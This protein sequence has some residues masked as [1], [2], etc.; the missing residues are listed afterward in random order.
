MKRSTQAMALAGALLLTIAPPASSQVAHPG[1]SGLISTPTPDVMQ[2][3]S[4]ALTF[5]WLDGPD[6]YL[7]T[8]LTNRVYGVTAG[9]LPNLEVTM[10][11]TE[12]VGWH[13]A[14]VPG[15]TYGNDRMFSAKYRIPTNAPFPRLAIGIQD[16]A[17]ANLL[18]GIVTNDP[19]T[20]YGH[21][22]IYALLGDTT[23]PWSWHVGAAYSRKFI[24]GLFGGL[25][26]Q[27]SPGIS[28][29]AEHDSQHLNYGLQINLH[30][31][32]ALK[33]NRIGNTTWGASSTLIFQL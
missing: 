23:G 32:V 20:Y 29:V 13:D 11:L 18:A 28:L 24:N 5:S 30:S 7:R 31:S 25:R 16:M 12:M 4:I 17:S 8:P 10:R 15:V 3:G 6:T 33:L 27:I 26:F 19:R 1:Y 22:T 2:E 9:V 21:S 14:T